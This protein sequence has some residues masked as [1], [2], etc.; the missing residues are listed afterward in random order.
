MVSELE[1]LY[2][3]PYGTN[4]NLLLTSE[5]M[6]EVDDVLVEK[7]GT[8]PRG[9]HEKGFDH[10]VQ[11]GVFKSPINHHWLVNFNLCLAC[12]RHQNLQVSS[13]NNTTATSEDKPSKRL[14][15]KTHVLKEDPKDLRTKLYQGG[16]NDAGAWVSNS[17]R[18]GTTHEWSK[19]ESKGSKPKV[20]VKI[21]VPKVQNKLRKRL[22]HAWERQRT[23]LSKN[24]T[25]AWAKRPNPILSCKGR[26]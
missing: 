10:L 7:K 17:P 6:D 22:K 9:A 13:W 15:K 5:S 25:W 21:Y 8:V 24:W 4:H 16:E 2:A 18:L 23:S 20:R 14:V 26:F 3:H 12:E 11:K 19:Q 1:V